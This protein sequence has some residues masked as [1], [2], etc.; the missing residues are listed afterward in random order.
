M[1]KNRQWISTIIGHM[2]FCKIIAVLLLINFL[3]GCGTIFNS[4]PVAITNQDDNLELV[5]MRLGDIASYWNRDWLGCSNDLYNQLRYISTNYTHT[6][7]YISG[8]NDCN[9]MVVELWQILRER[10]ITSL[11]VVGNLEKSNE[12]FLECNHAWLLVYSGEGAAAAI[13]TVT[14]DI[15]LWDQVSLNP[16]YK[17]YWEG[18]LYKNP[19]DLLAD[20]KDRW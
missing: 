1:A 10:G 18:F 7:K 16:Q 6:S 19:T 15:Y 3:T 17:Q 11:I 13:D 20:F 8:E 5:A 4:Q 9:D 12:S 2:M 14:A